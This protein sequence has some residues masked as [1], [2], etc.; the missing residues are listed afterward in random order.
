LEILQRA[1]QAVQRNLFALALYL[2][3]T[4]GASAA[5]T[6]VNGVL[7]SPQ[8][9][10]YSKGTLFLCGLAIAAFLTVACAAAQT[11][12]FARFAKDM[13]RPLWRIRDDREALQRYFLL[14]LFLNACVTALQQLSFSVSAL[15]D[16][17]DMGIV[18]GWLLMFASAV[19]TPL[20]AA[21]MFHRT[22][23]WRKIGEVLTPYRRQFSK[24]LMLCCLNGILFLFMLALL[25]M[26]A[27]QPWVRL[28]IDVIFGYFDCV[29]FCAAWFICMLDRQAPE[30]TDFEF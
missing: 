26:T 10:A 5:G 1:I 8:E 13:D 18:P 21:M 14:W 12:A 6:A 27:S 16:N 15:F 25:F 19:C 22:A 17:D 3:I 29:V 28:A 23:D 9:S 7:G 20:G 30:D 4:V 2:L 24:I 11:I